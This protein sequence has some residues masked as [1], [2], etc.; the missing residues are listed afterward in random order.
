[1]ST[2]VIYDSLHG[3]TEQVAR[4][5]ARAAGPAGEVTVRSVADVARSDLGE[6]RLLIVGAPTHRFRPSPPLAAFLAALPTAVLRG[7]RVAAFDT[8]IDPKAVDNGVLRFFMRLAGR[9]A[10]AATHIAKALVRAGGTL[11]APPEGFIVTGMEGP[12]REGELERAAD[13]AAKVGAP[14]LT[15]PAATESPSPRRAPS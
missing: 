8:R 13:W 2:L 1:M 4:A 3:N 11:A 10:F 14:A 12:L 9:N 5:I 7:A 15:T 6:V